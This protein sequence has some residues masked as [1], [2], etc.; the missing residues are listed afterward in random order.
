MSTPTLDEYYDAIRDVEDFPEPGIVFKDITP[1]LQDA[2]LF[3]GVIDLMADAFVDANVEKILAIESRGFLFGAPLS[4]GLEAGVVLAR[5]TG[6]LPWRTHEVDYQ[7][8]YGT[9]TLE[10]HQDSISPGERVLVVDDVLA[11]GGT[12]EG[13]VRMVEKVGGELVGLAFLIEL[14]F[15]NGR[16]KLGDRPVWR[17][18]EFPRT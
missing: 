3:S 12:A 1:L 13:A 14:T 11:T 6:K 7:L 9:D 10:I 4:L 17:L 15:L 8:E 16:E 2:R 18:L 5:K